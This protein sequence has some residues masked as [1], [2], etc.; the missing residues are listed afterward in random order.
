VTAPGFAL[1]ETA[2]GRCG[3]GWTGSGIAAVA[4]PESSPERTRARV[5]RRLPGAVESVQP[6][7]VARVVEAMVALLAGEPAD[8][9]AAV[10]DLAGVPDFH[11]Q[12]YEVTRSIPVGSTLSY[13][14]VASRVGAPAAAQAVGQALGAN[15]CPIVVPCHRVLASD[16]SLR[17]FSAEGGVETKRRM[18]LAEGATVV[19]PSLF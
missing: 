7:Q 13:G 6:P 11:R 8:L 15:P 3:V 19:A 16:G 18:L 12:V 10:L 2:I 17:G 14:Q 9:S 1:F 5:L 4:L